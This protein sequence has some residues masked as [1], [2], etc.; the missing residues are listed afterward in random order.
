MAAIV[1]ALVSVGAVAFL[2]VF[3][4]ALS[5]EGRS[6]ACHIV[7]ILRDPGKAGRE[8]DSSGWRDAPLVQIVPGSPQR[9]PRAD[10]LLSG[11]GYWGRRA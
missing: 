2:I 4:I 8:L 9:R 7:R 5:G 3:L 1:L 10:R 6:G 11:R